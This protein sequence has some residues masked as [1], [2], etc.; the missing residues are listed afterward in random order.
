MTATDIWNLSSREGCRAIVCEREGLY[1]NEPGFPWC[2]GHRR[3]Y[4]TPIRERKVTVKFTNPKRAAK[5]LD[6][7]E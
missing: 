3:L 7:L 6:L 5:A 4:Y 1:C 2:P